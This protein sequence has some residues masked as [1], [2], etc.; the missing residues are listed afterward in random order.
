MLTERLPILTE[1]V[2]LLPLQGHVTGTCLIMTIVNSISQ[3]VSK[4]R[5]SSPL[6]GQGNLNTF[7]KQG[8]TTV[9]K[10]QLLRDISE[11]AC[12]RVCVCVCVFV[13]VCV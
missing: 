13:C 7:C 5:F 1:D 10:Q 4:H 6:S 3:S 11:C 12:V 2:H 9:D 8:E